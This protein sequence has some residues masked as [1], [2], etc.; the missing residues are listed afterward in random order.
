VTCTRSASTA[1]VGAA[2]LPPSA[3]YAGTGDLAWAVAIGLLLSLGVAGGA[4]W[5]L[6]RGL[7]GP[8][9]DLRR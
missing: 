9:Q 4:A 2:G 7:V 6:A 5:A 1:W 8:L 3:V